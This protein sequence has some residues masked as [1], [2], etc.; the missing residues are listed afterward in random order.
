M[1]PCQVLGDLSEKFITGSITLQMNGRK[2]S[3]VE[4][5]IL[6]FIIKFLS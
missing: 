4:I 1:L 2:G 3:Q 6:S 5:P